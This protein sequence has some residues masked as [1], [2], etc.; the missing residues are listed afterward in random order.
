MALRPV[1][2][3]GKAFCA[4]RAPQRYQGMASVGPAMAVAAFLRQPHRTSE[5]PP[6]SKSAALMCWRF[7]SL[8]VVISSGLRSLAPRD[9]VFHCICR[10]QRTKRLESTPEAVWHCMGEPRASRGALP[11]L[12]PSLPAHRQGCYW[13]WCRL[14]DAHPTQQNNTS[15]KI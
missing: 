7:S 9:L 14:Q 11:G 13:V 6:S 4:L 2:A 12:R 15:F 10:G 8:S 1:L 3:L 5:T